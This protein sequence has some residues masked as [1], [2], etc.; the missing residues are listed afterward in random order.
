MR[1]SENVSERNINQQNFSS[2]YTA[3]LNQIRN[4]IYRTTY[5]KQFKGINLSSTM[6]SH[7]IKNYVESLNTNNQINLYS[8][9]D[10]TLVNEC[11]IAL[12]KAKEIYDIKYAE[13]FSN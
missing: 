8:A 2:G 12:F 6:I 9:W 5:C 3:A 11:T 4:Q 1:G 13:R 7:M 10:S